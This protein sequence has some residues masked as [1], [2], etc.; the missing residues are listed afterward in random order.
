MQS[1]QYRKRLLENITK[2]DKVLKANTAI[3]QCIN[4][5]AVMLI[6]KNDIKRKIPLIN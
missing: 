3:T 4:I 2:D 5:E 1:T 6:A